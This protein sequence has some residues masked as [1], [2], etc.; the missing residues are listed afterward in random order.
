M[1]KY[2]INLECLINRNNPTPSKNGCLIAVNIEPVNKN[3]GVFEN[4]V[5]MIEDGTE[6]CEVHG[7][8]HNIKKK[9][10]N[11]PVFVESVTLFE[12]GDY[13][14]DRLRDLAS[15][16]PLIEYYKDTECYESD[17]EG[18]VEQ[19]AGEFFINEI[20][21]F[22]EEMT[23]IAEI[24]LKDKEEPLLAG[25]YNMH[26]GYYAHNVYYSND[27]LKVD[28]TEEKSI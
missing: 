15:L 8:I 18:K 5:L 11:E 12:K 13:S 26:N 14:Y 17:T 23:I 21:I 6:C 25:V 20:G 9:Y 4:F 1:K 28:V 19:F 27:L 7:V 16:N 22:E 3:N 24:K 2:E 10:F